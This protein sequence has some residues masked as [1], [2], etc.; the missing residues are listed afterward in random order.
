MSQHDM[1]DLIDE[2]ELRDAL[3][4]LRPNRD[5]FAAEVTRRIEAT[6]R[7]ML[8]NS[9]ADQP[10]EESQWLRVAASVIPFSS[11]AKSTSD[12]VSVS[13]GT[14]SLGYKLLGI[15][16]LPA[17]TVLLMVGATVFGIVRI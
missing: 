14:S 16:A 9:Q 12:A 8:D 13:L 11:F 5:V 2:Q 15:A 7:V 17:T 6:K 4:P 1:N 10:F 3:R